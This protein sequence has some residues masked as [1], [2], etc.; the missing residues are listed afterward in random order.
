MEQGNKRGAQ[1]TGEPAKEARLD[2]IF[3]AYRTACPDRDSSP[4]FM[5][6][7]WARIE[8]REDTTNWFGRVA[9]ALVTAALAASVILGMMVSSRSQSNAFFNGTFV[10]ALGASHAATL[11]PLQIERISDIAFQ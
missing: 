8:A 1:Y 7:L 9:K 2:E 10:D 6:E 4:N 5:P 3:A 11:E